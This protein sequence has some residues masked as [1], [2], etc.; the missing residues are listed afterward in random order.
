MSLFAT[1]A[2]Y[3]QTTTRNPTTTL[4]FTLILTGVQNN[5][6]STMLARMLSVLGPMPNNM[7]LLGTAVNK[8][9]L[10][11]KMVYE[12]HAGYVQRTRYVLR[13]TSYDLPGGPPPQPHR[14]NAHHPHTP[15]IDT[16]P[17]PLPGRRVP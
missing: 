7:L 17:P 9:F 1:P 8:Y 12:R 2:S 11:G 3:R 5:S 10:S 4:I 16:R 15:T 14:H 13:A 6:I